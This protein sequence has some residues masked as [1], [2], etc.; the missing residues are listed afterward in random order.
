[1][2]RA[3]RLLVAAVV[4]SLLVH[5]IVALVLHPWRERQENEPEVV[6]IYHRSMTIARS[7]P[8]PRPLP[9]TT[10]APRVVAVAHPHA[11]TGKAPQAQA[12]GSGRATPAPT[13]PPPTPAPVAAGGTCKTADVA[14]A[15]IATPGPPD[16][17][18]D[19]RA[20]DTNGIAAVRVSLDPEGQVLA[21]AVA[22]STGNSS[23]DLVAVGMARDARYSAAL[24]E[25]KPVAG[26]YTFSVKFV[27]W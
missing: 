10:I 26:S 6:G 24:H 19:A 22:Q 1:M 18:V 27:A 11:K 7:R 16:I 12:G 14:A 4:L 23:L 20:D 21:A 15:V 3:Q 9:R 8:T 13:P 25:C 17:P 2:R 5:A